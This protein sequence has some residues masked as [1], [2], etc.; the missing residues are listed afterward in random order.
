M[1]NFI[2]AH[3]NIVMIAGLLLG[4]HAPVNHAEC[5][6]GPTA[7]NALAADQQLAR[8]LQANDRTAILHLLDKDWAVISGFGEI[9]EGSSVFPNGIR[10]GYRTVTTMELSEPRVR[11]CVNVALVTTK[12]RIAVLFAGK[13]FDV[14]MRQT[15]EL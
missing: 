12:V 4:A 10:A 14:K 15:D 9:A 6:T 7:E 8:A 13:A 2:T 1:M 5:S 11:L 3:V